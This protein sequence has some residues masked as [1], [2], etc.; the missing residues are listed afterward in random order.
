LSRDEGSAWVASLNQ[1]K[2]GKG[3]D[4]Q[5]YLA[6]LFGK[7]IRTDRKTNPGLVP[8]RVPHPFLS[9]SGNIP[10]KKLNSLVAGDECADGFIERILFAFPDHRPRRHWTE[11]GIPDDVVDVWAGIV[12]RLRARPLAVPSKGKPHPHVVEFSPEGKAQWIEWYD[13]HVDEVNAPAYDMEE[14][15]VDGKLCDFA[16]RQVLILHLLHLACG[17]TQDPAVPIPPVPRTRVEGAVRLWSYFRASGRRA[18]WYMTG[19]MTDPDARAI[20]HWIRRNDRTEFSERDVAKDLK[21]FHGNPEALTAALKWLADRH[22]V[23]RAPKAT[24]PKGTRGQKPSSR[25]VVHP[26]LADFSPF[27]QYEESEESNS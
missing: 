9:V 20:L 14:L 5:V 12:R 3:S 1:Y 18:R 10:P 16:G 27:T 7:P 24:R 8:I 23:R 4:R 21:R 26:D 25:W 13:A 11:K 15:G 22:A 2:G 6:A 19:G 17:A